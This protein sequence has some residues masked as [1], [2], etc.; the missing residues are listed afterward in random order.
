[1]GAA[2]TGASTRRGLCRRRSLPTRE[3][4]YNA[5]N[6]FTRRR[7]DR[8]DHWGFVRSSLLEG[9]ELAVQEAR[10]HEMLMASDTAAQSKPR[11]TLQIDKPNIAAIAD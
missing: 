5:R 2:G 11:R 8:H 3:C 4:R 7:L 10:R 6:D 1:L 9:F